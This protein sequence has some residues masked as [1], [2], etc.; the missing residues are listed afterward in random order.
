[1]K[2]LAAIGAVILAAVIH[3]Q[4]QSGPPTPGGTNYNGCT[5]CPPIPVNTNR[6]YIK[7]QNQVFTFLDTNAVAGTN[8]GLY[9][10]CI[11]F[12]PANA[13]PTI[14]AQP[15]GNALLIKA[16][17]FD[18]SAETTRD[19][20]LL[21]CDKAETPTWKQF[22]NFYDSRDGWLVQGTVANWQ[23]TDPMWMLLSNPAHDCNAFYKAIPY[24]GPLV[25][26][27]Q[28]PYLVGAAV[29]NSLSITFQILDL[30]GV[31]NEQASVNVDG[32]PAH[33]TSMSFYST[34]LWGTNA[35]AIAYFDTPYVPNGPHNSYLQVSSQA[36]VCNPTNPP[37]EQPLWFTASSSVYYDFENSTYL[38]FAS[39]YCPP[40]QGTNYIVFNVSKQSQ[41]QAAIYDPSNGVVAARYS[42]TVQAGNVS[43]PWNFTKADGT[44]Y[45][46]GTYVVAFTNLDP[47]SLL[48]TNTFDLRGGYIRPGVGSFLTYQYENPATTTGAYLNQQ[49]DQSIGQDLV[50][51]FK[52][53][54]ASFGLTGYYPWQVGT[55]RNLPACIPYY[56]T[57]QTW[58][59][60]II[61][62]LTNSSL[63]EFIIAQAHG[64]GKD[65]GGGGYLPSLFQPQDL[66][67]VLSF[68][69][70]RQRWRLRQAALWT[71]YSGEI[72]LP[73]PEGV[74][75]DWPSGCGIR[76]GAIQN[77][78]LGYKN[79][80]L[81]FGGLLPQ[82]GFG[83]N[84]GLVTAQVAEAME[85]TWVCGKNQV[86]GGCVPTYSY[87][88]AVQSTINLYPQLTPALPRLF[89]FPL[90]VY[91]SVYDEQIRN[92]DTSMVNTQ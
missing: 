90:C 19:F 21:V 4:A 87:N 33:V 40:V 64:S 48:F 17:H 6:N 7:Y 72:L 53:L 69:P 81:F 70:D 86:P 15:F 57:N 82:G 66:Q 60:D 78:S 71:C 14:Q 25:T 35:N 65:I 9:Q 89:G 56:N 18:Y 75:S 50:Y 34:N 31:T 45:T 52:N 76:S 83:G 10:A 55:N 85:I 32:T 5:N 63:S 38:A 8:A 88:F 92:L 74:Y 51:F 54:Y 13:G 42:G 59:R 16:S 44:P 80:G 2:K 68:Y 41:I 84:P 36:R 29:S 79:C 11:G 49:A 24:G 12:K 30:S 47:V 46:N 61:P 20:S 28:K 3:V 77:N 58:L 91:S 62:A 67:N 27:F 43:L 39:D 1:M 26:A 22:T 37:D 73:S 23:V